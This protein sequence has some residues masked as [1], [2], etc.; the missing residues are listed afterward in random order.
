M[1]VHFLAFVRWYVN[2][3]EYIHKKFFGRTLSNA[4]CF[5]KWGPYSNGK[6]VTSGGPHAQM[7]MKGFS[8]KLE[9][10]LLMPAPKDV[11]CKWSD[12]LL[13]Y[14]IDILLP[15]AS[16][17][18][19]YR[20]IFGN[21]I[22]PGW[23]CQQDETLVKTDRTSHHKQGKRK[24]SEGAFGVHLFFTCDFWCQVAFCIRLRPKFSNTTVKTA[25]YVG[26]RDLGVHGQEGHEFWWLFILVMSLWILCNR[27][28]KK[29]WILMAGF[30]ITPATTTWPRQSRSQ[31]SSATLRRIA[32][33]LSAM[34]L[35]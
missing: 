23:T 27:F 9:L 11:S 17:T 13:D 25:K 31:P 26:I 3:L 18:K 21:Q 35:P 12:K 8:C 14:R 32:L 16:T 19:M 2:F 4:T 28:F 29:F 30:K 6:V 34:I 33:L 22:W 10:C 1:R 5:S 15:R 7:D 24:L 20:A